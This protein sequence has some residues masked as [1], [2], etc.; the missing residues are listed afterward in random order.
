[1]KHVKL[2][3]GTNFV[4]LST[5]DIFTAGRSLTFFSNGMYGMLNWILNQMWLLE[6]G[7]ITRQSWK[8]NTEAIIAKAAKQII[9]L[10]TERGRVSQ[11]LLA[12]VP[13]FHCFEPG[14]PLYYTSLLNTDPSSISLNYT[15]H[16]C[17]KQQSR[18]SG[19]KEQSKLT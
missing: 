9:H 19:A 6:K 7:Y 18:A 8:L 13:L 3:L 4:I 2:L 15:S 17:Y 12:A 14:F 10:W 5:H 1:M 16:S 11:T